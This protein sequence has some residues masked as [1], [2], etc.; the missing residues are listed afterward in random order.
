MRNG[1][2]LRVLGI[3]LV[4]LHLPGVVRADEPTP[5]ATTTTDHRV[6]ATAGGG[7]MMGRPFAS[8][9]R[10]G[11]LG[12][13]TKW[14]S[15]GGDVAY[16]H[17]WSTCERPPCSSAPTL[18]TTMVTP[19]LHWVVDDGLELN[20]GP[21]VG[22]GIGTWDDD[23]PSAGSHAG[24]V[25]GLTIGFGIFVTDWFSIDPTIDFLSASG[26]VFPDGRARGL[27]GFG[28]GLSVHFL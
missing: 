12:R 25:W 2:P 8:Q 22:L 20:V 23:Y 10:V 11:G 26:D 9:L 19:R 1:V 24:F 14:L 28:G 6:R 7:L 13:I 18:V 15:V 27:L 21:S 17:F 3:V 4:G 5:P 16:L